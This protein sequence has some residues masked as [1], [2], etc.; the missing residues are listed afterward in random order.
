MN[1]DDIKRLYDVVSSPDPRDLIKRAKD[2]IREMDL[3]DKILA[4]LENLI[5][6]SQEVVDLANT[7]KKASLT[8]N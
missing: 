6:L 3:P 5:K 8:E 1:D 7:A 2:A 4:K